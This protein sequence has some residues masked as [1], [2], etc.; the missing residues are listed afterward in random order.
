MPEDGDIG[1]RT[2]HVWPQVIQGGMGVGVS[3]WRLARAVAERGHLGVVSGSLLDTVFVRRLQ[4]G[5]PGGHMRRAMAHFPLPAVAEAAA[6]DH[7]RAGG[8]AA[9]EPYKLLTVHGLD[10]SAEREALTMLAGFCE[11]W[12]AR[13]GHDG[14]VGMN[15]LTKAALPNAAFLYGAML[16]GVHVILMGAGIP[17]DVP[18]ALDALAEGREARLKLDVDSGP[19]DDAWVRFDPA[20]HFGADV[21]KLDRP[22]FLAIVSS[23]LL[24]G[25]LAKKA[26]GRVDGFVVE[27]HIAGGHNA[28]PREGAHAANGEPVYGERDVVDL[29]KMRALGL[30]FWLA[31][32][33]GSP[34]A[35]QAALAAGAAGVQVGSLFAFSE[36]SGIE[37]TLKRAV[38][39]AVVRG[40]LEIHTDPLAS[41]TGYPFKVARWPGG[42]TEA[43]EEA[44]ERICDLGALRLPFRAGDG[45]L[46]VRCPAAPLKIFTSKGGTPEQAHGRRCLCNGLLATVGQAQVR[47]GEPELPMVTAGDELRHAGTFLGGRTSYAAGDVLDWLLGGVGAGR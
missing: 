31:G 33:A 26:S 46:N 36:E 21:P 9:S 5:D 19:L 4:D 35:L 47:E 11:V 10:V 25:V 37:P 44:R 38:L 27:H 2:S 28:P 39:A 13:E 17:R 42:P 8:R 12:L 3:G 18:A 7:F 15:L 20:R 43:Q 45:A 23:H 34:E 24:A 41:P 32:G 40:E 30:P 1:S 16:A 29:A 22:R 6:R 14:L